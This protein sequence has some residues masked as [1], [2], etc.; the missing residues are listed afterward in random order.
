MP[1]FTYTAR[2]LDGQ[3]VN[4]TVAAATQREALAL[5]S[6]K[7]LFPVD[8]TAEKPAS[9]LGTSRR[10]SGQVMAT[11][12]G[13][14]AALMRSGVP[15]LRSLNVLTEQ[16]SNAALKEVLQDVC[17]RVED[18]ATLADA[19]RAPAPADTGKSELFSRFRRF[20]V[21]QTV[22]FWESSGQRCKPYAKKTG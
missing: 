2:T 11:S 5:L 8:V 9:R 14:M 18:G 6:G 20:M 19:N 13:Q 17:H 3:R 7:S 12:Y 16:T 15:L 4:G 21:M 22:S 1:D 10:V